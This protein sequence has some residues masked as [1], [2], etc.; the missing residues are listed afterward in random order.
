MAFVATGNWAWLAAAMAIYVGGQ[1]L[2]RRGSGKASCE[3]EAQVGEPQSRP[4]S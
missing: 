4:G 3:I 2:V 1:I